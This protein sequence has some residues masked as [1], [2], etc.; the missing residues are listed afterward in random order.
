MTKPRALLPGRTVV[1]MTDAR[2]VVRLD[3]RIAPRVTFSGTPPEASFWTVPADGPRGPWDRLDLEASTIEI[4]IDP[5]ATALETMIYTAVGIANQLGVNTQRETLRKDVG[6]IFNGWGVI[7]RPL[8]THVDASEAARMRLDVS[9]IHLVQRHQ[10]GRQLRSLANVL[11][12]AVLG[13]S[14]K[15]VIQ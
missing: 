4:A 11:V 1:T 10:P 12:L 14:V 7:D 3:R 9:E 15:G 5:A 13:A 6:S 2:T 8:V